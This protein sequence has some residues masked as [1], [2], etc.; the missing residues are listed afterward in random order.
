MSL[1]SP[2]ELVEAI[3]SFIIKLQE[4]AWT[5]T[6]HKKLPSRLVAE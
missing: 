3:S 4:A 6:P 1:K 5:A 2:E